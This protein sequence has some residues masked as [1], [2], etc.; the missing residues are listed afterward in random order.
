MMEFA[1]TP[2]EILRVSAQTNGLERPVTR[3][4]EHRA[5]KILYF[6]LINTGVIQ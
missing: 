3:V 5:N 6:N 2:W 1:P 4:R